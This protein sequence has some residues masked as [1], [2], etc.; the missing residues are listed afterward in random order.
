[1]AEAAA[2]VASGGKM[3]M[4]VNERTF[5]VKDKDGAEVRGSWNGQVPADFPK[6]VPVYKGAEVIASITGKDGHHLTL[7]SKAAVADIAAFYAKELEAQGW[8]QE[9]SMNMQGNQ[10][11]AYKK[12]ERNTTVMVNEADDERMIVLGVS[13]PPKSE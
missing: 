9:S 4:D 10:I 13:N 7:K 6:D 8:E 1:M 11:L 2:H 12:D 3:K 5:Q